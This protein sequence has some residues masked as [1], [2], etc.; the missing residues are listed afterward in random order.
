MFTHTRTHARTHE[1]DVA[2][3]DVAVRD[4]A[5]VAGAQR[6]RRLA[7]HVQHL[8]LPQHQTPVDEHALQ[9]AAA[10]GREEVQN[11]PAVCGWVRRVVALVG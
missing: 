10:Q 6:V 8:V 3:F 4:A 5:R 2:R 11:A 7:K 1:K 9:A